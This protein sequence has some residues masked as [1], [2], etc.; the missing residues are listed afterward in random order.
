MWY[1]INAETLKDKFKLEWEKF[2][3]AVQMPL[4]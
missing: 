1:E 4:Q 3:L 2:L